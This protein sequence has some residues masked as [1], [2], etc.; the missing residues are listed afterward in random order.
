[1]LTRS[2][3]HAIRAMTVL[4]TLE[5]GAFRGAHSIA[6]LTGAPHTYLS[7]LL[8]R[9]ART[10][11]LESQKGVHGGFRLAK[12]PERIMLREILEGIEDIQRWND[13]A[14]G[15]RACTPNVP[16]PLHTRWA[17]VRDA[18]L[19]LLTE[20]SLAELAATASFDEATPNIVSACAVPFK[21][22]ERSLS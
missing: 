3:M 16:C 18:Y 15:A 11:L 20:T 9:L 5:P 6:K 13:C 1:V 14:F 8:L 2:G 10:G 19:S 21:N 7:K 22:C 4:A 12:P 17:H